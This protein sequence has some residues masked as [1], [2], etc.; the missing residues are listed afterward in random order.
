MRL[1]MK[2]KNIKNVWQQDGTMLM[3]ALEKSTCQQVGFT[4]AKILKTFATACICKT[5]TTFEFVDE[6]VYKSKGK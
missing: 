3:K 5:R 1:Y 6:A 2:S 4:M